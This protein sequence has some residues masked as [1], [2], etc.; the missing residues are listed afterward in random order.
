MIED[1][2]SEYLKSLGA[3]LIGFADL[4]KINNLLSN[5]MNYGIAFGIKINTEVIK[6]LKLKVL[7]VESV[8]K[9]VRLHSYILK[10]Y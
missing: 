6:K 2:L 3:S 10:N 7:Y 5:G 9:F 1:E 8:L 4:S